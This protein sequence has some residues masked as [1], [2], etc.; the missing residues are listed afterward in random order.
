MSTD[1]KFSSSSQRSS[2]LSSRLKRALG[3][4]IFALVVTTADCTTTRATPTAALR[5][6]K[7]VSTTTTAV[8]R[9]CNH[10]KTT[11]SADKSDLLVPD[12]HAIPLKFSGHWYKVPDN[13][14]LV[15]FDTV[16]RF[17]ERT[18][19]TISAKASKGNVK[20]FTGIHK[21][22]REIFISKK[23]VDAPSDKPVEKV[24]D[25]HLPATSNLYIAIERSDP[26]T[27]CEVKYISENPGLHEDVVEFFETMKLV[28]I[29]VISIVVLVSAITCVFCCKATFCPGC[30]SGKREREN[31]TD[32]DASQD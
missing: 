28:G 2:C 31:S 22:I 20:L 9:M 8:A 3:V 17:E 10:G 32:S 27:P 18:K 30:C 11:S 19:I 12:A 13:Q 26:D 25:I 29:G 24:F 5:G 4:F 23:D 16:T 1:C 15:M 21:N 6:A 7:V 14:C